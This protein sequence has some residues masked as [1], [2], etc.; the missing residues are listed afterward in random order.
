MLNEPAGHCAEQF[1]SS[2]LPTP[3]HPW[4]IRPA[5][6]GAHGAQLEVV[7]ASEQPAWYWKRWQMQKS[8]HVVE[9][10]PRVK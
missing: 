4:K 2:V 8:R 9:Y 7:L 3:R 5:G 6:H 1:P 10:P